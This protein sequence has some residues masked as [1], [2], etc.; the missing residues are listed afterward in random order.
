V[1][2]LAASTAGKLATGKLATGVIRA[3]AVRAVR[4]H[5][6]SPAAAATTPYRGSAGQRSGNTVALTQDVHPAASKERSAKKSAAKAARTT[7][8]A[9]ELFTEV[10]AG[11]GKRQLES[12]IERRAEDEK[13]LTDEA[14]RREADLQEC[15][16]VAQVRIAELKALVQ[17]NLSPL[18]LPLAVAVASARS[19]E[20]ERRWT[21]CEASPLYLWAPAC[22]SCCTARSAWERAHPP[23]LD[24]RTF[25]GTPSASQIA[26]RPSYTIDGGISWSTGALV[27]KLATTLSRR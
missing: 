14:N 3:V 16:L 11:F 22:A 6:L 25:R 10:I 4:L 18:P 1:C 17:P 2:Q 23:A 5:P 27:T 19:Q 15:K 24:L 20:C 13:R 26:A 9:R 12:T 21:I 7:G 8:S